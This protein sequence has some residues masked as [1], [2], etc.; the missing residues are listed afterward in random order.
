MRWPA[1]APAAVAN[2]LAP[3]GS[4]V[5]RFASLALGARFARDWLV[6]WGALGLGSGLS[7][8]A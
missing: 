4:L 2:V 6:V 5:P 8:A 3:L 7:G 1:M